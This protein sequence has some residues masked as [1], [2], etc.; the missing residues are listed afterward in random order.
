MI[1]VVLLLVA[2]AAPPDLADLSRFPTL[3]ATHTQLGALIR[4]RH[5]LRQTPAS[6]E[7]DQALAYNAG[8][9]KAWELLLEAHGALGEEE[10]GRDDEVT[11]QQAL[12]R[13]K[14][15]LGKNAWEKGTMP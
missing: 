6:P 13:L 11:R 7:R 3:G 14:V 2:S 9:L 1:A 4:V 5:Q 8:Q 15:L 12:Q 10:G